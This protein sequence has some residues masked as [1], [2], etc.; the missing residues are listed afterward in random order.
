MMARDWL[1]IWGI[2]V[3]SSNMFGSG[4]NVQYVQYSS[5]EVGT[6]L[7]RLAISRLHLQ[8]PIY[9]QLLS[10]F[11]TTPFK[12]RCGGLSVCRFLQS[13]HQRK[14]ERK[15]DINARVRAELVRTRI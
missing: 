9:F 12:L 2:C 10:I 8:Y 11:Q 3:S 1:C 7:P 13:V 4:I 14:K 5:N 6:G 15:K